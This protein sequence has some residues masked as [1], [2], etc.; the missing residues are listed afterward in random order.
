MHTSRL[1]ADGEQNPPAC[2]CIQYSWRVTPLTLHA[3]LIS[4]VKSDHVHRFVCQVHIWGGEPVA[5]RFTH[6]V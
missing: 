4:G 5:F 2:L 1:T 3:G 6:N